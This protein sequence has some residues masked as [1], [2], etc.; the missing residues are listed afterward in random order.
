MPEPLLRDLE[1]GSRGKRHRRPAV[2]E[3]VESDHRQPE[4]P[5][6]L[7][8]VGDGLCVARSGECVAGYL[9]EWASATAWGSV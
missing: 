1:M 8:V 6:S 3:I 2:S 9:H 4:L 5:V 7:V